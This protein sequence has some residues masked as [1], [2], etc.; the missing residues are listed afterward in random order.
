MEEVAQHPAK[1]TMKPACSSPPFFRIAFRI[2]GLPEAR[3]GQDL[4]VPE[5]LTDRS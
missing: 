4:G 1:R 2:R 5:L 3:D